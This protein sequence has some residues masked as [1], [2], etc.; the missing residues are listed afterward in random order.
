MAVGSVYPL[1]DI[2]FSSGSDKPSSL[3]LIFFPGTI[4]WAQ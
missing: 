3:K 4:L 1:S 2:A